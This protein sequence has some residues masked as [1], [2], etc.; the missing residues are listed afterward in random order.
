MKNIFFTL[1]FM[2]ITSFAFA[3]TDSNEVEKDSKSE[4]VVYTVIEKVINDDFTCQIYHYAYINGRYIGS[5][6]VEA[7]DSHPDCGGT[8]IHLN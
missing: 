4:D 2:L 6:I 1:A 7:P 8:F 3:N 5:F